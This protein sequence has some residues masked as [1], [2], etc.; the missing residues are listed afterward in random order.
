MIIRL[1]PTCETVPWHEYSSNICYE[2]VTFV[3][4]FCIDFEDSKQESLVDWLE[5]ESIKRQK[6]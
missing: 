6:V 3:N 1:L 4:Q 5:K 2:E